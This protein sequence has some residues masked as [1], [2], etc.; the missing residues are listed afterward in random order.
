MTTLDSPQHPAGFAA[1]LRGATR[2]E[3]EHAER[4]V[5]VSAL[6]D[7]QLPRESYAALLGQSLLFYTVLEEAAETWRPDP[8]AGRFVLDALHRRDVLAAD[9]AWLLGPDWR[10]SVH[11]L[12]ATRAYVER[13]REVCFTSRSAFVAHHYTRYLGDLSGGQIIR[14]RLHDAYGLDTDGVRFYTFDGI[15]KAKPFRDIYRE[16]LDGSPW[17]EGERE[18]LVAEANVAFRLNRAVFDDL[19]VAAGL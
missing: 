14:R 1:E 10:A 17:T 9:L 5:F 7:G 8:V 3:H 18:N 15:P 11:P 19:A 4:S 2:A 12:A 16:L 13:L 6:L